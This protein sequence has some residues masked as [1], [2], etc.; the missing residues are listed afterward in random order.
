MT[1]VPHMR[2]FYGSMPDVAHMASEQDTA[3]ASECPAELQS[4]PQDV[5]N[6]ATKS[7][8]SATRMQNFM[9]EWDAKSA[10]RQAKSDAKW[11]KKL[12][13]ESDGL[14]TWR[15]DLIEMQTE[16]EARLQSREEKRSALTPWAK[17]L[18]QLQASLEARMQSRTE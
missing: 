6:N 5:S 7:G 3:S 16:F 9:M 13:A 12:A 14:T 11:A 18:I 15:H 8:S 2:D 10:R 4:K 1:A 17:D